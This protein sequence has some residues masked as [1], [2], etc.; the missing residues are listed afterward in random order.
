[1]T[2]F[3]DTRVVVAPTRQVAGLSVSAW[4][5]IGL[6]A[7][8]APALIVPFWASGYHT[9]Q[10]TLVVIYAIAVMGLN[11]LT[12]YNGQISLGHGAF[13]AIGAYTTA[14]MIDRWNIGYGWTI[15]SA[16]LTC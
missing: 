1:M 2:V 10:L 4:R 13:Y 14:I 8:L 6:V 12:G 15:P 9:F 7:A 3:S 11:L 16:G 5:R